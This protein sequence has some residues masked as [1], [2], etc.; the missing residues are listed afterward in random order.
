MPPVDVY[1]DILFLI[2]FGMDSLCLIL[3]SKLLHRPLPLPRLGVAAALGGFYGVI[4]LFLEVGSLPALLAD[5]AVC[6]LMCGVAFGVVKLWLTGGLY[7]LVSMVT[8][9]VMTALYTWLNRAGVAQLLPGGDEGI[10]TVAFLLLAA[11]GG[12]FTLLWGRIF[13]R[14]E[15]RR[16]TKVLV[17][18]KTA[19]RSV[20]VEGMIDSGNL[21]TDP[22]SGTPVVIMHMADLSPLLSREL[23]A[24]LAEIPLPVEKVTSLPEADRL[25]LIPTD[26]AAGHTLLP[27]FQM[28]EVWLSGMEGAPAPQRV[29]A[30]ISPVALEGTTAQALVPACLLL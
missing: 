16:A 12:I 18:V 19:Q 5:L 2:N 28:D 14:S 1:A 8:G 6:F 20:T 23:Q 10:S 13:R 7:V 11:F 27:A 29:K 24:W 15:S 22:I 25:R 9:G 4:A 26:T 3:T 30:L 17:T 21:L